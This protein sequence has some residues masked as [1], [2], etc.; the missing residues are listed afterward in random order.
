MHRVTDGD[1]NIIDT[2]KGNDELADLFY[3]LK[4]MIHAIKSRDQKIYEISLEEQRLL[5][6]QGAME[7]QLL[8]SKINPHFLY[9]TLETIR[10][11]AFNSGNR[12][13]SNAVYL[14]G[15]YMRYNLE[16]SSETKSLAEE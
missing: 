10:M 8:S 15:K 12:E 9:N 1:Y 7:F 6:H 11:K 5:T 13:V 4:V 2:F 3:D 14:L 16:S